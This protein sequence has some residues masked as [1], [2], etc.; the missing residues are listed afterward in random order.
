MEHGLA[1]GVRSAWSSFRPQEL[2]DPLD[3]LLPV[4]DPL[5]GL[6]LQPSGGRLLVTN[7]TRRST[8]RSF[9]D[10]SPPDDCLCSVSH[11]GGSVMEG[12]FG[13]TDSE[14]FEAFL[15]TMLVRAWRS[16]LIASDPRPPA[17]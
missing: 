11:C 4:V 12:I 16:S 7:P 9:R 2:E 14:R 5:S 10:H 15:V 8:G 6:G 13:L 1:E 3:T 17:L